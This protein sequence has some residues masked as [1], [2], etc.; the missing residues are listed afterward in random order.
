MRIQFELHTWWL[1]A[2]IYLHIWSLEYER[3]QIQKNTW[4]SIMNGM[5][6]V[7]T[8]VW[9]RKLL[10]HHF[11]KHDGTGIWEVNLCSKDFIKIIVLIAMDIWYLMFDI[12]HRHWSQIFI[13]PLLFSTLLVSLV[14]P[15]TPIMPPNLPIYRPALHGLI[16]PGGFWVLYFR[17]QPTSNWEQKLWDKLL[18]NCVSGSPPSQ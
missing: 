2:L 13:L 18:L 16:W 8:L 17:Y 3:K 5:I 15:P 9:F 1:R 4:G 7:S 12:C 14:L 11:F 10:G 6:F